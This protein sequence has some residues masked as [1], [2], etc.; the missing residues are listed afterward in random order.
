MAAGRRK[1]GGGGGVAA[2][3]AEE[4]EETHRSSRIPSEN[5]RC[6]CSC[7]L[8]V[9]R[10]D[11]DAAAAPFA[12]LCLATISLL[13][14]RCCCCCWGRVGGHHIERR[15]FVPQFLNDV[16]ENIEFQKFEFGVY[17]ELSVIESAPTPFPPP[18]P[19]PPLARA[20]FPSCPSAASRFVARATPALPATTSLVNN[21]FNGR[22]PSTSRSQANFVLYYSGRVKECSGK[23]GIAPIIVVVVVPGGGGG[24]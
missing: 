6:L 8:S 3:A 11:A 15:P 14:G 16:P 9:R 19:S 5:Y 7:S 21:N 1:R 10:A 17:S 12:F 23:N 13:D 20:H 2:A 24:R 4:N 18:P 22:A